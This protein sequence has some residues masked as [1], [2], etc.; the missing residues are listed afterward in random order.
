MSSNNSNTHGEREPTVKV[1]SDSTGVPAYPL[2]LA[3]TSRRHPQSSGAT[4]PRRT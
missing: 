1:S 2:A 3:A 4:S